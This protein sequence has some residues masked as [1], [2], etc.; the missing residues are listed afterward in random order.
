MQI[1]YYVWYVVILIS[2]FFLYTHILFV[3]AF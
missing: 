2:D 3:I 1:M